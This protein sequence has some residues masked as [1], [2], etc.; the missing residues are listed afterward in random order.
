MIAKWKNAYI[1]FPNSYYN[2]LMTVDPVDYRSIVKILQIMIL[3]ASVL[4]LQGWTA[5]REKERF[6]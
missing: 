2:I 4:P 1:F 3:P 5:L 6:S